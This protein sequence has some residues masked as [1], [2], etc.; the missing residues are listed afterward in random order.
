MKIKDVFQIT[1]QG[2]LR[3]L[4]PVRCPFCDGIVTASE[5]LV[6]TECLSDIR[7]VT[8]PYCMKCG[9]PL[10]KEEAEYCR[11]CMCHKHDYDRGRS[12]LLYEGRVRASIYRFKYSGRKEYARAYARLAVETFGDFLEEIKPDALVPVPLHR[13]RYMT[14]GYNQAQ[15]LADEIGRRIGVPVRSRLIRRIRNTIPQKALDLAGRQNNLKKAFKIS[16]N[17]VK[18]DTIIIIDDIYTTGSTIDALS[19]VL[20]QAGV[21]HIFFLTISGGK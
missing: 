8:A 6:C 9:K 10:R 11:D 21:K 2:I 3:L 15:L 20:R 19:A 14:R 4:Y 13:K 5:G 7:I 18:L 17:D 16:Q 12:L 1:W